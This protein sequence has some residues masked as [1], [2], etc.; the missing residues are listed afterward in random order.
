VRIYHKNQDEFGYIYSSFNHM[1]DRIEELLK[2]VREQEILVQ[3]AERIQLQSQINPHFLYNSFYNIKFMARN[4]DYDQIETFVTALAKYYR[5]LNKETD[6]AISLGAEAEHMEHYIE[7]QQMRFGDKIS[8]DIGSVP[9][10]VASLRVPKLILQ[11]IA[12]NAYNYGL[13]D[14]LE[15]G[16]LWVRYTMEGT[17]LRIEIGDNGGKMTPGKLEAI[18]MQMNTFSGEPLNHALTNI[19]RR[20]KLTFGDGC[21]LELA[22]GEEKGLCVTV[23]LDTDIRI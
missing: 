17:R 11:P 12:E 9:P 5:F 13:R 19:H 3:R 6:S 23:V 14:T 1:A 8:V 7:I 15:G 2:N 4:G 21:G 20:L 22:M 10:A 18:G 16:K